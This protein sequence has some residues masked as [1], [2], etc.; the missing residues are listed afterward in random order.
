MSDPFVPVL[1]GAVNVVDVGVDHKLP[2]K[3]LDRQRLGSTEG[4]YSETVLTK[5][6]CQ[7]LPA[8]E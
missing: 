1:A 2:A 8:A 4:K 5:V 6:S 7:S 3:A